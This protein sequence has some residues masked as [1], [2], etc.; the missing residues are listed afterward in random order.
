[1]TT[2]PHDQ[3][4]DGHG[5]NIQAAETFNAVVADFLALHGA[6]APETR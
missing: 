5:V 1:M 4:L 3:V 6:T 2:L